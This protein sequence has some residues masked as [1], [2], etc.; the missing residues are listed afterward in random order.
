MLLVDASNAFNSLNREAAIRNDRVYCPILAPMLTNTYRTPS[1]LFIDGDHILSQE[2]TTQG[3]PLAMAMYAI[4]T[5]PLI[6]KLQGDVTQAWYA[7]DESAG[8]KTSDLRVWCDS[9]VSSG[10][11]FG[12]NP[13]KT[14][15]V[16]KPE[17][18]PAAEEHFRGSGVNNTTQGHRHLGAHL[19]SKSFVEEFIR[20]K[21]RYWESEIKRLSY[22]AKF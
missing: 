3:D 4:G 13:H 8:G 15:L 16:D 20:D 9:L 12:Y 10:P 22:N 19:G 18:L 11:H 5:L 14:W 21:I 7:D 1:R 6:H 17:L 2:G